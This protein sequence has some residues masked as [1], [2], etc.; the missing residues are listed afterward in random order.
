MDAVAFVRS[1]CDDFAEEDDRVVPFADCDVPVFHAAAGEREFGEFVVVR[2]E[3]RAALWLVV[4]KFGDAP[5]DAE[6][7]ERARAAS[8]FIEDDEAARG[9]VV[10]DV[11]GFIHL[12][13]EGALPARE[14][15]ATCRM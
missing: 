9:G 12:D 8:D 5:C 6:A 15:S 14:S 1:A 10:A 13:H 11:S 7:V 4:Q 2:G 3:E